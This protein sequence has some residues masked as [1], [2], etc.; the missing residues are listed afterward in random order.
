MAAVRQLSAGTGLIVDE[1][2]KPF[3]GALDH[4]CRICSNCNTEVDRAL[5]NLNKSGKL[6][7]TASRR[8]SM[9]VIGVPRPYSDFGKDPIT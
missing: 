8:D 9:P 7:S 5:D 2:D 6:F 4:I 3:S 1:R